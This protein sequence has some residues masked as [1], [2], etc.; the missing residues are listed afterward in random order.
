M[1]SCDFKTDMLPDPRGRTAVHLWLS[2][3]THRSDPTKL[4]SPFMEQVA[5]YW[6]HPLTSSGLRQWNYI[7]EN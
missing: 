5:P 6:L 3:G 7:S 2:A 4:P 1:P